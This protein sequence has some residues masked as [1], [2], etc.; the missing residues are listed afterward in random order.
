M[1]RCATLVRKPRLVLGDAG[2]QLG[3]LVKV[4]VF[5]APDSPSRLVRLNA[6]WLLI[7]VGLGGRQRLWASGRLPSNSVVGMMC[8]CRPPRRFKFEFGLDT[9]V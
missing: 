7:L 1:D 5:E 2:T 3:D 6:E 8:V 4:V 9:P